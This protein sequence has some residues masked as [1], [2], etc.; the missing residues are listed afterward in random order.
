MTQSCDR[1]SSA[2]FYRIEVS[3][4]SNVEIWTDN[5]GSDGKDR[6]FWACDFKE[7]EHQ[8]LN[9]VLCKWPPAKPWAAICVTARWLMLGLPLCFLARPRTTHHRPRPNIKSPVLSLL[10]SYWC[11]WKS[12]VTWNILNEHKKYN[13]PVEWTWFLFIYLFFNHSAIGSRYRS[14]SYF[15]TF[16]K[17]QN[18]TLQL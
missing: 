2:I 12:Y 11:H 6:Y 13:H 16:F 14:T 10:M 7:D 9:S 15:I 18:S 4:R 8:D 5:L 17:A 1:T 3:K